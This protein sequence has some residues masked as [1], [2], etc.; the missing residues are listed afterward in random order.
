MI[1]DPLVTPDNRKWQYYIGISLIFYFGG[2]L[3]IFISKVV[4]SYLLYNRNKNSVDAEYEE[5][6]VTDIEQ[7]LYLKLVEASGVLVSAQNL[8][9][10]ILSVVSFIF[11][12]GCVAIYISMSSDPIE[13][14]ISNDR[15]LWK[16]EMILY[17]FFLFH[18]FIRF[19]AAQDKLVFWSTDLMTIV[20]I[21]TMPTIFFQT[22][23]DNQ[24]WLGL[25]FLRLI[26]LVK[27]G[28]ILQ[29]LNVFKTGSSFEM[30]GLIGTFL[31]VWLTSAGVVHLIENTGDP[32]SP[33]SYQNNVTLNYFKCTYFLLVT[34][35]TVGYGDITCNTYLGKIFTM[36]FIGVGLGLFASYLPAI[37]N[38]VASNTKYNKEFIPVPGKKF[39]IVCGYITHESV[40]SFLR[41]FLHPDR[42]DNNTMVVFLSPSHPDVNIQTSLKKY[43]TRACYF[44]GTI[45]SSIDADRMQIN[46]ADAVIILCNKKCANPDEEDAANITRVIAVKNYQERVRCIVQLIMNNNKVH[47]MNCPQ[48]KKEYGDA[49][50]CI[51]ELKL[52]FMAQSCNAPGFSTLVGNLFGM[53]SNMVSDDIPENEQWKIAYMTGACNEIYCSYLSNSF[54]G[55]TFPQAV[56]LCFEKLKLL[57]IAIELK[58]KSG[59]EFVINP[60][61]KNLKLNRSTRGFFLAQNNRDSER[62]LRYCSLCHKDLIEPENMVKCKCRKNRVNVQP[63]DTRVEIDPLYLLEVTPEDEKKGAQALTDDFFS[64][65][66]RPKFDQT[67]TFYWCESRPFSAAKMTSEEAASEKFYNHVVILVLST[68]YSPSLELHRLVL[69]LR[70]S[71][72]LPSMLKK[73][74]ILGNSDFLQ[75]EWL[76]LEN[77]PDVHIVAGSPFNRQD[78]RTINVNTA[79][80][81]ILLSPGS[82]NTDDMEHEALSDRKVISLT[83]N[84]KAMQ[85]ETYKGYEIRQAS[86]G[87]DSNTLFGS[88]MTFTEINPDD[89]PFSAK[90]V[91]E[92]N[93]L[94]LIT[95]LIYN[96]NAMFLDQ[97]D[98]NIYDDEHF[99]LTQ[100]Y[101]CG[102]IF[103]V[104][105]LDSLV[106]ATY[107]NGDILTIVQNLVTGSV[108]SELDELMAEGISPS[109]SWETLEIAAVRNRCRIAQVDLCDGPLSEYGQ[110]GTFGD[111]F[112]YALRTYSMICLGLFRLRD[113]HRLRTKSTKRYVITFPDFNFMLAPTD[114]VFVLMQFHALRKKRKSTFAKDSSSFF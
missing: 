12:L 13:H 47:L 14:C 62:A 90:P 72:I 113:I 5:E 71:N 32:W 58:T 66:T 20:D 29:I 84:L 114:R 82:T 81:C 95:E 89:S 49:I 7:N 79:D 19:F 8:Q 56:E 77:F 18:F 63:S 64:N 41:D 6:D 9:G 59:K 69:P 51:N 110:C 26:Y 73:V 103:T 76:S 85:F 93:S 57:L 111:L 106:S 94:K 10:R 4:I 38:Y 104:S 70:A 35:S 65:G 24:Y 36:M 11:N 97:D 83:L 55:M 21:L 48:W 2:I 42:N 61:D 98:M 107:F 60:M 102:S 92:S 87:D 37:S 91:K 3:L 88:T 33:I 109:G 52:G 78:L 105:V 23:L 86:L 50:I 99:Y 43:E 22:V 45:Y 15:A 46:K 30:I 54:V 1:C 96:T 108:S 80:M 75:R 16:V 68:K 53:R 44:I 31:T 101:A 67:G 25:R 74:V 40:S 17:I 39:V 28:D 27:L 112:L 100:P 34:M